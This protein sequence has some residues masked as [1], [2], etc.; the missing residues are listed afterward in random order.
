MFNQISSLKDAKNRLLNKPNASYDNDNAFYGLSY[1]LDGKKS[2]S[3]IHYRGLRNLDKYNNEI[4][5]Y[6]WKQNKYLPFNLDGLNI[7]F[8][9]QIDANEAYNNYYYCFE[10]I[11]KIYLDQFLEL[12]N[13]G[14]RLWK[15][16]DAQY[17]E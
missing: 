9:I 13:N 1:L 2:S 10:H 5:Y 6:G 8:Y 15:S 16:K 14:L 4:V 3:L 17:E 7:H 11:P 12:L